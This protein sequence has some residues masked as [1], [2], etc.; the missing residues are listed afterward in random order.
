MKEMIINVPCTDCNS[1]QC[2]VIIHE[3]GWMSIICVECNKEIA[4]GYALS[5]WELLK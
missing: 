4:S 5:P 1:S 2:E 3:G